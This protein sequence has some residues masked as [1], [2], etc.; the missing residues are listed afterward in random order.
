MQQ[1]DNL[2]FDGYLRF[3]NYPRNIIRIQ[4]EFEREDLHLEWYLII[5]EE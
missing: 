1:I 4:F 5:L 2:V 3:D